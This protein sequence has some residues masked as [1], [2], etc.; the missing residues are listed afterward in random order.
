MIL[1]KGDNR[2]NNI[3]INNLHFDKANNNNSRKINLNNLSRKM[4]LENYNKLTSKK[5]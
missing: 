1:N 5:N 2:P 3:I 4:Y